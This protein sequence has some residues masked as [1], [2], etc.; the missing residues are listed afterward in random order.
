MSSRRTSNRLERRAERSAKQIGSTPRPY[1]QRGAGRGSRTP[2]KVGGGSRLN[3]TIAGAVLGVAAVIALILYAVFETGT[4]GNTEVDWVKAALD[5]SPNLPGQYIAPNPGPDGVFPSSDDRQ[6]IGNGVTWPFCTE[7]QKASKDIGQCYTTNPPTSGWHASSPAQ[8]KVLENPAPKENLL[9]T[10]EHGGVI[11]W[12]NSDD[13]AVID[14]LANIV[15][16]EIKRRR[17]VTMTKYTEM[18][19]DTIALTAWTRLDKFPVSEFDKDRVKTF[20]EKHNKRFNP[21]MF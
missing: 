4:S 3:W 6:H 20:I 1:R 19:P 5:D 7:Q 16:D 12:Y 18:E 10:M 2:V 11:V 8:F 21:E 15:N 13:Q 17:L 9:H 14:Q